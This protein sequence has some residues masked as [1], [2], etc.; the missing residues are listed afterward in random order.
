M[1]QFELEISKKLVL[2]K[3]FKQAV[4]GMTGKKIGCFCKKCRSDQPAFVLD[5]TPCHAE[6]YANYLN[7]LQ[8]IV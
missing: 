6:F 1:F 4:L 7:S 5:T 8:E 3:E 2:D